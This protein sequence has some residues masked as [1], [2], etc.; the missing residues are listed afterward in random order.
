MMAFVLS[1][2]DSAIE[3]GVSRLP[4]VQKGWNS[5]YIHVLF[6]VFY[7]GRAT[8]YNVCMSD[9]IPVFRDFLVFVH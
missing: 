9:A 2:Y 6:V 5:I 4:V 7:P 3:S 1:Q 8:R